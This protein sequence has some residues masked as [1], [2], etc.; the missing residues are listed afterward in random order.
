MPIGVITARLF[1]KLTT[2]LLIGFETC[3]IVGNH[4]WYSKRGQNPWLIYSIIID[5]REEPICAI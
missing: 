5:P 3:F 2:D 1:V 4:A